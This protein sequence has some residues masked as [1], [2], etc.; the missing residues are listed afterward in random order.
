MRFC[1][2]QSKLFGSPQH[3]SRL[4]RSILSENNITL[5]TMAGLRAIQEVEMVQIAEL[6]GEKSRIKLSRCK[7]KVANP[8]ELVANVGKPHADQSQLEGTTIEHKCIAYCRLLWM[9]GQL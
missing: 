2:A 6:L 9:G 7:E 1:G 4:R 8:P 3:T 5:D